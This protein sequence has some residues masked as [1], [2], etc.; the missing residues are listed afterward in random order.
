LTAKEVDLD[1][2]A[3]IFSLY[4]N[5][6]AEAYVGEPISQLEHAVQTACL[7]V[8]AG[9][10]NALVVA[11]LLHDIGHLLHSQAGN[12]GLERFDARHELIGT[13]WVLRYFGAEVAEPIHLHVAAKRYLCAVDP[14]YV[15]RLSEAS[16]KSLE[17]Q[18][19]PMNS[20][21]VARYEQLPNGRAAALLRRWDDQAKVPGLRVPDFGH[22]RKHLEEAALSRTAQRE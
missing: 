14:E 1:P 8:D 20:V 21:A 5:R 18:G 2:L 15:Q 13:R 12:P 6:G 10:A 11:A 17:L 3:A 19:G 9:A 7:A 22:Y 4:A 16:L